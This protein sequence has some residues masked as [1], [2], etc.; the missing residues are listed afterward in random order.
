MGRQ[1]T[2]V[3]HPRHPRDSPLYALVEDHFD[4]FE[5]IYDDT[6]QQEYGFWRPVI[7]QVIDKYLDCA[8]LHCGFARVRCRWCAHEYLLAFSCKGRYFC[9][10]CHQK[11]VLSF[12][13]WATQQ[14]LQPVAHSQYVFTIP[15]MLRCYFKYDRPPRRAGRLEPMCLACLQDFPGL[16]PCQLSLE[17][18]ILGR[19][20]FCQL[21]LERVG[22]ISGAAE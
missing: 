13:P 18:L 12:A 2:G 6:Y 22:T 7:R 4:Y 20:Q 5:R 8:D 11:R 15:K 10:S 19:K 1:P 16:F 21:S 3:Y 14:V 17:Q 9:P